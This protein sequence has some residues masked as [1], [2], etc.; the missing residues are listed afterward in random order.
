MPPRSATHGLDRPAVARRDRAR[1]AHPT[2]ARLVL[3]VALALTTLPAV[4]LTL[5]LPEGGGDVVGALKV[6][7]AHDQDTLLDI[8]RAHDLGYNEITAANPNVDPWVPGNGTRILVPTQFVLPSGPREGI[9]I[10]LGQMRLFY[11]PPGRAGEPA[12]VITH[13]IGIGTDIAPTPQGL[14]QIVRKAENPSWRPPASIR[15][16]RAQEGEILPAVV[17]PGPENPLGTRALY[18]ALPEYLL[19]G[20]NRPWGIGMRVSSGCIRLYP[21]DIESLYEEVDVG[22]PVRIIDEPYALGEM[23][24]VPVLQAFRRAPTLPGGK[25]YTSLVELLISRFPRGAVDPAKALQ[26]AKARRGIPTAIA[27][28]R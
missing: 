17:L 16:R 26:V 24:G 5:P 7:A 11:F 18:L 25:S 21:E 8:A 2:P 15:E 28:V 14:T 13:P 4:A 27:P 19:H 9:V 20:T 6:I 22:T 12:R 10:N 1:H 3:L 23:D